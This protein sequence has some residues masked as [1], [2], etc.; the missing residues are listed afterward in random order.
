MMLRVIEALDFQQVFLYLF[1][2]GTS[3]K[4]LSDVQ[5]KRRFTKAS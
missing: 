4:R 3:R 1:F 2:G 5:A